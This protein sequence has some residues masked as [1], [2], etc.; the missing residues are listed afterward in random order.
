V[1]ARPTCRPG[2]SLIELLIV[3]AILVTIAGLV[4]PNLRRN[5]ERNELRDAGRLLQEQ[6]GEWRQE[7]LET[8]RPIWVEF[9]WDSA[10]LRV[11][12]DAE[13]TA[14]WRA[15]NAATSRR[16][17]SSALDSPSAGSG[18][19]LEDPAS[20]SGSAWEATEVR[21]P[22]D[23]RFA[24]Q[25]WRA[26]VASEGAGAAAPSPPPS[27]AAEQASLSDSTPADDPTAGAPTATAWSRP[28]AILPDGSVQE[29]H[30]WLQL[31]QRWQCPVLW[32]GATGQLEFGPV[33]VVSQPTN[34]APA[35]T[36]VPL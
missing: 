33:E 4:I 31:D 12:R 3:L 9:G 36:Q 27:A 13:W 28:V 30:F 32:R 23:I 29:F 22:T 19:I 24:A 34:P 20:E 16:S 7:A 10:T 17:G 11:S 1:N 2:F 25:R 18:A 35:P 14:Q 5:F 21:L 8:G 26:D 6:L 15:A